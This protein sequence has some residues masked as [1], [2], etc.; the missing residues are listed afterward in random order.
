MPLVCLFL[1]LPQN[2]TCCNEHVM[3]KPCYKDENHTPKVYRNGEIE[4]LWRFHKTP[5]P[6]NN[7]HVYA[8]AVAIDCEMGVNDL[9]ES[10]LIRVSVVDYF[11]GA[12]LIDSLVWPDVKMKHY[13]TRYSGVTFRDMQEARRRRTCLFGKANA[14]KAIWRC[15]SP[16]TI[17]VGH[18]VHQDL[19][20]LRWIHSQVVDTLLIEEEIVK[21]EKARLEYEQLIKEQ[22]EGG[23]ENDNQVYRVKPKEKGPQINLKALSLERLNREIQVKGQGHDSV[24]DA[25]ASR[26]LLHWHLKNR[27]FQA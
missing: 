26:D 12:V 8:D 22:T 11:S 19:V 9:G 23:Q 14:R 15:V 24:E 27:M 2:W 7:S 20:S 10:E 6:T 13:N 17:V 18:A 4:G 25:V 1:T 5:N 3:A 16:T 21:R